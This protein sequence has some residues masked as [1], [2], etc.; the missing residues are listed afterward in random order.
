MYHMLYVVYYILVHVDILY[1]Y[2]YTMLYCFVGWS[3]GALS[4][5]MSGHHA[6]VGATAL[7]AEAGIFQAA[8]VDIIQYEKFHNAIQYNIQYNINS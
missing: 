6:A 2:L 3:F 8:G 1:L 4:A 5:L 7:G